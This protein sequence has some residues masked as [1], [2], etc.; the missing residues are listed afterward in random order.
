MEK[1]VRAALERRLEKENDLG[2]YRKK[3]AMFEAKRD[4]YFSGCEEKKDNYN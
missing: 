4:D 2:E 3:F 1:S